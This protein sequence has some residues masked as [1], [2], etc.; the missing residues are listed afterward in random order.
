MNTGLSVRD[1]IHY[2]EMMLKWFEGVYLCEDLDN[3][4][5]WKR[6]EGY[7]ALTTPNIIYT[8]TER[9]QQYKLGVSNGVLERD[10]DTIN[11]FIQ[12]Y[13]KNKSL[14]TTMGTL[15]TKL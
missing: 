1:R 9:I 12:F 8:L 4:I 13:N 15:I 6:G 2:M 10:R 3:P 7:Y 5:R 14:S 11:S